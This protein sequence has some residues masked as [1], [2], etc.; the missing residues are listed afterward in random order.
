MVQLKSNE[1]LRWMRSIL[2]TCKWSESQKPK[3]GVKHHQNKVALPLGTD[4]FDVWQWSWVIVDSV[5]RSYIEE[6]CLLYLLAHG[7]KTNSRIT[8]TI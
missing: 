8:R 6:T 4:N 3:I 5:R 7:T 2:L 1:I